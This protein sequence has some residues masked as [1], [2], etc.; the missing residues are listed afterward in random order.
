MVVRNFRF[1]S[2]PFNL[3]RCK[4]VEIEEGYVVEPCIIVQK[5]DDE[6]FYVTNFEDEMKTKIGYVPYS[7]FIKNS[8][9]V[10]NKTRY[11]V[12]LD[13]ERVCN[14]DFYHGSDLKIASVE[15]KDID[16]SEFFYPPVW[17][18]EEIKDIIELKRTK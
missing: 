11:Y 18:G 7:F 6:C 10:T 5:V 4:K 1:D 2:Y 8:T 14:L 3:D 9:C 13:N 16:D 15:F 17:F 12:P